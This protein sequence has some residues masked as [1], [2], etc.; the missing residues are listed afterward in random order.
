M[1]DA[2]FTHV[3]AAADENLSEWI[4]KACRQRLLSEGMREAV[5]W[6]REHPVE[7]AAARTTEAEWQRAVEGDQEVQYL[8]EQAWSESGGR[9]DGPTA[10]QR[11]DAERRVRTLLTRADRTRREQQAGDGQ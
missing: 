2:L 6:E 4:A 1:D 9:G 8:A 5:A 10:E 11:A 7:A 3:R